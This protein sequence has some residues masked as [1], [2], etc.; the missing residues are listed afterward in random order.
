[1]NETG[2]SEDFKCIILRADWKYKEIVNW[3]KYA[4]AC[5]D[6]KYINFVLCSFD[7]WKHI[8]TNEHVEYSIHE[9]LEPQVL[10]IKET[11]YYWTNEMFSLVVH[12]AMKVIMSI[13][14][15]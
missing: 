11:Y 6:W 15:K 8:Y 12:A 1:M 14:E 5:R 10:N 13:A 2:N 4:S 7:T 9:Y 3:T